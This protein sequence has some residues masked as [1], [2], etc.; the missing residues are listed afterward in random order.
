MAVTAYNLAAAIAHLPRNR[1]Y[2]YINPR[3]RGKIAIE[4][5]VLPEGPIFIKRWNPA[6]G[7]SYQ[8]AAREPISRQMLWRLAN[9]L[10][11]GVPIQVDRIFGGSYNTRSVLETLV[12][13]TPE[14]YYCRPGRIEDMDGHTTVK[15]GQKHLL[16]LPNEPHREGQL[17]EKTVTGMEVSEIPSRT[18]VYDSIQIPEAVLNA[19]VDDISV[20]RRHTQIQIAL[21]LIGLSLGYRTWIAQNDRGILYN[22]HPLLELE[23]VMS[24]P[25]DDCLISHTP[26]AATSA[27]FIDCIWFQNH[28]FMPAVMEVEHTTGITSGL[29]RM[30]NFQDT[31]PAFN[32]RYVIVAPDDDRQEAIDKINMPQFA[33]M[34]ARYFSYSS[35]EELYYFCSHRNLRGVND[36]FLDS[37][38]EKVCQKPRAYGFS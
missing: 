15:P 25:D 3:T 17:T 19:N 6:K 1:Y 30:K 4:E 7:E 34:D 35:V 20:V 28:R 24:A 27:A 13:L 38:M 21:Y 14:F 33:S 18:I 10:N 31:I 2:D 26:G 23:G 8:T 16:W 29:T 9:A 5:V 37:Y 32:T 22:N 36:S 12:A 11:E